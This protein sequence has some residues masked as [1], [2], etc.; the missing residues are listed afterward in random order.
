MPQLI[1]RSWR[2]CAGDEVPA[3]PDRIAYQE[4]DDVDPAFVRA[5]E[6]VLDR[7]RDSFAEVPVA[8]VLS[9][10]NGRIVRRHV[11]V[12]QQRTIMDRA[13]AAEGFDFSERSI[14]TNGIGTVLVE[15]RPVLVRGP[16]HYNLGLEGLTCAGTP[17]VEPFTGRVVGSF[18]LACA[19]RDVHPLMQVMAGDI[20][21]QIE[22]GL[23]EEAG[24][25]RRR[26]VR[27]YL[28]I[29][30]ASA[31]ALV[32]DE[33]TVLANRA[34]LVH[35]GPEV[36]PVLWEFLGEH[37]PTRPRRMQVPLAGGMRDAVV[38]PVDR[39]ARPAFGIR[40]TPRPSR[41]ADRSG[42]ERR[43]SRAGSRAAPEP[44]HV[45]PEV[46]RLLDDVVRHR[47]TVAISGT[48]GSGK[49][50]T[51]R[52]VLDARG[53]G[54]V[55]VVAPHLDPDWFPAA[56]AAA[57]EGRG[58]VVRRVHAAPCPSAAQIEALTGSGAPVALTVD[59]DA[60]D[61]TVLD[62]LRRVASTVRLPSLA[63]SREHLP[64]LVAAILA[65]LPG[66]ASATRFSAPAWDRL[67]AWHWPGDVA[68]LRNTVT[69][70]ARRSAGG[71]VEPGDLPAELG[72]S[73]RAPGLLETAERDAVVEALRTAGGN[74][75]RAAR[76]LGIGRNTLYRKLREFGIS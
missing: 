13:S 24:D 31:G 35:T 32:V 18:S 26:L 23:L 22:D 28:A 20:A 70:S 45:S 19:T 73:R 48:G 66:P 34:G 1:E 63:G 10:A 17:I 21:R 67:L 2:R 68:E 33:D 36:H 58:V 27:A 8:M 76:A 56:R 60:A 11:G 15:R 9:D 74:R 25:R 16:E 59:P 64:A 29:D 14:G 53:A 30:R 42:G 5:A 37:G 38:E 12:R 44:L 61:G 3:A 40:L 54:D 7:L 39:G 75:T 41:P 47:E 62:L 57:A 6:P 46:D 43:G 49:L 4:P 51:A 69:V 52:R 50:R 71:I 55:L 72:A 65:E